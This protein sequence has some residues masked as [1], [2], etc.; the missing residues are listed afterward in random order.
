M[1]ILEGC[2]NLEYKNFKLVTFFLFIIGFSLGAIFYGSINVVRGSDV[3]VQ[4]ESLV[5]ENE[6]SDLFSRSKSIADVVG[7]I[8]KP[9]PIP[10]TSLTPL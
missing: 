6:S 2:V 8:K 10:L 4:N 1:Y 7:L 3:L 5:N 9:V